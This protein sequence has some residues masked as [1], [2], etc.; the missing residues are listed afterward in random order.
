MAEPRDTPTDDNLRAAIKSII[1][2]SDLSSLTSKKVRKSLEEMFQLDLVSEKQRIDE[3]L[4]A[5]IS[6]KNDSSSS[7]AAAAADRG[8]GRNGHDAPSSSSKKRNAGSD[9]SNSSSDDDDGQSSE[10]SSDKGIVDKAPPLKKQRKSISKST[11]NNAAAHRESN[12][13]NDDADVARKLHK[14][15]LNTRSRS[16]AKRPPIARKNNKD[17]PKSE[18]RKGVSVYSQECV[19]SEELAEIMGTDRMARKD[20]VSKMWQIFKERQIQDPKNKQ[21]V[22]CDEQLEKLFKVKKFKAFGMMKILKSHMKD[23][24]LIS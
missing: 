6:E 23:P 9:K 15:E 18:G 8:T 16:C 13:D 14:E 2:D 1:D 17:K 12:S 20:V 7:S 24:K 22:I 11:A 4:M 21:Y 19:L 10:S 3:M 5:M